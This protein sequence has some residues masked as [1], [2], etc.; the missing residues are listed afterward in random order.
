MS[1]TAT[2]RGHPRPGRDWVPARALAAVGI[3][4]AGALIAVA[5]VRKYREPAVALEAA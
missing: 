2:P 4:F 5:T 1:P 3:A